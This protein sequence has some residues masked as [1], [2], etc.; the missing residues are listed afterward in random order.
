MP[1]EPIPVT[2]VLAELN[3]NWNASNVVKPQLLEMTGDTDSIRIDLN[4]G[5]YL[6]ARPGSPTLEETPVGNWK[7]VNRLYNVVVDIQTKQN[8]Q[9]L[10]DLMREIR[11]ICHV[12]RHGLTNFQ[13]L[14]FQ[15]FDEEVGE[16]V[17]VW[18]GSIQLQTVN[19][20]VLAETS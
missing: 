7:Y 16:Q 17:N 4:R 8:R 6:I 10:Y 1:S 9:R 5:D 3:T 11:K 12:R 19:E 18:L 14:Q 20:N 2:E 13:R 15:N